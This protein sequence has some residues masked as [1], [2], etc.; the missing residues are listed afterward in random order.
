MKGLQEAVS[1]GDEEKIVEA[2]H[3]L[4]EEV[5][6]YGSI[7]AYREREAESIYTFIQ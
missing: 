1:G 6:A 5:C 4:E 2:L 3:D 7:R